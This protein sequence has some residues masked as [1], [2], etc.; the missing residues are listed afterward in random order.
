MPK[1]NEYPDS[2]GGVGQFATTHWSV[3]QR[4]GDSRSPDSAAALE[5]LCTAYWYPLYAYVRGSGHGPEESRDLTQE[6]F[7]R[8]L[9]KKWISDA[10]PQRGRFRSFLL[11][12]LKRFLANEWHHAQAS[13]RGGNCQCI[14]MDGLEAEERFRLEPRDNATPDVLFERSW[15]TTLIASV[16]SRLG[17]EMAA[18]GEVERFN[19]LEP[20]LAGE[21]TELGYRELAGRFGVSENTVK[22]WVLRLRHRFR[23]LLLEE[24]SHTLADG[25]DPETE[26]PELFAAL[27]G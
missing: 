23:A 4:A 1:P 25:E 17:A 8:L 9:E 27:G 22:S 20:T 19:A 14:A 18:A 6:F 15:A 16:Q 11:V 24:I 10:D 12:A 21:Q 26:L 13:K 5:K 2:G 7:A 3:V